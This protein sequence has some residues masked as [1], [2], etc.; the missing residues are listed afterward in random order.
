MAPPGDERRPGV[1]EATTQTDQSLDA[2]IPRGTVVLH[3]V[4]RAGAGRAP[5][6]TAHASRRE[7]LIAAER[8]RRAGRTVLLASVGRGAL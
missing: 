5:Y 4:F 3:V 2:T 8:A 6:T 1:S 7:A